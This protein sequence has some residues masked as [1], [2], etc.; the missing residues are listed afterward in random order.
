M[1]VICI[2]HRQQNTDNTD[3][4]HAHKV[5]CI[6]SFQ[7]KNNKYQNTK[8]KHDRDKDAQSCISCY[9]I[10]ESKSKKI[11]ITDDFSVRHFYNF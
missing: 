1:L 10:G 4:A 6:L 9:S 7:I 5:L 8:R 11:Y 2:I 3:I